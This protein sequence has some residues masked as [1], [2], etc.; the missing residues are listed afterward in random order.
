MAPHLRGRT[1]SG[2]GPASTPYR[3]GSVTCPERQGQDQ[4]HGW[5]GGLS[6]GTQLRG[7]H[8]HAMGL[9]RINE[10]GRADCGF[11]G[12]FRGFNE[13]P[14]ALAVLGQCPGPNSN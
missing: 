1:E 14:G 7:L 11:N 12:P 13:H 6:A 9:P 8:L 5:A 4:L 3:C 2:S 10:Q